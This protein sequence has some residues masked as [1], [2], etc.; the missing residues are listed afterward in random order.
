[1]KVLIVGG[2]IGGLTLAAFLEYSSV[3]YEIVEK[4]PDW[5]HQGFV[6]G[7]WDNGRDIL[8]KLGLADKLDAE[9]VRM[10]AYSIQNGKGK[11]IRKYD[12]RSFYVHYGTAMTSIERGDL[13]DWLLSIIDQKKI[14]MGTSIKA[15]AQR[16]ERVQVTLSDDSIHIFDAVIGADGVHSV[17]RN[18]VFK[19]AIERYENWRVWYTRIDDKFNVPGTLTEYIEPS[20]FALVSKANGKTHAS[21][22]APANHAVWDTADGRAKRL[23]EVFRD[24]SVLIP[25]VA[26]HRDDDLQPSDLMEIEMK[27]WTKG[28]VALLGDAAHGFGPH[29]GLG[30]SMA[31]EDAYVLAGELMRVSDS[32]TIENALQA[33]QHK[34][35]PRVR[36]ARELSHRIRLYTL[37]KSKWLRR[38]MDV[39]VRFI[40]ESYLVRDYNK[41]LKEEI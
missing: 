4:C 6:I 36:I 19:D 25:A 10:H 12:L 30:A 8:K 20:E 23:K 3:E 7:L 32:Y 29:A 16:A 35:M 41:L 34:R 11:L 5:K 9:G 14:R 2:G 37:I 26:V 38:M 24:Q 13:H 40:P 31:M 15:I 21:F 1:M 22:I 33:Y 18:L 17:V 28:H 39:I 27:Q